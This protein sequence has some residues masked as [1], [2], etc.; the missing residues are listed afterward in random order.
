MLLTDD[1]L[2][3]LLQ[4]R[5]SW[6]HHGDTWGVPGGAR[7]SD[8]GAVTAAVREAA[9]EAAVV[10]DLVRADLAF[11]EDHGDWSY[12][13]IV[14]TSLGPFDPYPSDAESHD[15]RWVPIDEVA[16]LPLMPAFAAM[17]PRI[18]AQIGRRAALIVDA[19]NVVGSRPDGWWLDRAGAT[20]RLRDR[21]AAADGLPA[22]ALDLPADHWWP[23]T[24]MVVEGAARDLT[25]VDGVQVVVAAGSGDDTIVA[26]AEQTVR[27]RP[28]DPVVVATADRELRR[29][30]LAVGASVTGPGTLRT[31]LSG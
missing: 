22:T 30:V 14:A 24:S 19:A 18:R 29:R 8:E 4:H 3:V 28:G 20:S 12:T 26:T 6:S 10:P 5:A 11:V 15:I 1:D 9:E 27:D 23:D 2:G 13:T 16:D 25:G 31:A 17:W 7:A 21:L